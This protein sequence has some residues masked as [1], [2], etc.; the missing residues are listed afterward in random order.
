M[1]CTFNL[2]KSNAAMKS[3]ISKF[4]LA[5]SG[6][7][8]TGYAVTMSLIAVLIMV[9][10]VLG[11]IDASEDTI[12]PEVHTEVKKEYDE[13]GNLTLFD[14]AWIM[15]YKGNRMPYF[16]MD[17]LFREYG[18]GFIPERPEEG[19]FPPFRPYPPFF[20]AMPFSDSTGWLHHP[21]HPW[22]DEDF[23]EDQK[24]M[25][26]KFMEGQKIFRERY[27]DYLE[28]H[29]KLLDK[30]FRQPYQDYKIPDTDHENN[31]QEG[32]PPSGGESGTI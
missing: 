19:L 9:R 5:N 30:Y 31:K 32:A 13:Q 6:R 25:I 24:K 14:S 8:M 21:D 3:L 12:R 16:L 15:T 18:Y 17:S 22:F 27:L 7:I 28:E 29:E 23:L 2:V 1:M 10:P 20:G 11:Q 26:E 4:F